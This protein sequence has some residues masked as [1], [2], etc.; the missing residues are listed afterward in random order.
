[1]LG[2]TQLNIRI[3]VD[4]GRPS[5]KDGCLQG[6][7]LSESQWTITI[8][9]TDLG[10]QSGG[11]GWKGAAVRF[12]KMAEPAAMEATSSTGSDV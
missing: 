11:H 2:S 6:R 7:H 3:E 12:G 8:H 5:K 9:T 4:R 10:R 1:M